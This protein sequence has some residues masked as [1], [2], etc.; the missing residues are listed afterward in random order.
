MFKVD[1]SNPG[2]KEQIGLEVEEN[3]EDL[4]V[5][6]EDFNV[7]PEDTCPPFSTVRDLCNAN[8]DKIIKLAPYMVHRPYTAVPRDNLQKLIDIFRSHHLRHLLIVDQ[9]ET[10]V[11]II[12]RQDLF[13]YMSI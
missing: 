4:P 13:S 10:L 1:P 11:G 5:S 6:W 2:E 7:N 3:F 9:G 8:L 12:T